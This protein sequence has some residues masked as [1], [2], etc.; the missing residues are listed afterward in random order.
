[1]ITTQECIE[2]KGI[3]RAFLVTLRERWPEFVANAFVEDGSLVIRQP[4]SSGQ[5]ELWITA[6]VDFDE[7]IIGIG[8]G[9]S[10]GGDWRNPESSDYE[11]KSSIAFIEG[12]LVDRV[13]GCTLKNGGGDIGDLAFL[14][15][16]DYWGEVVEVV[17]WL[18]SHDQTLEAK[19][20]VASNGHKRSSHAT[21]T[22][23]TAPAD[24]H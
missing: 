11:F 23:P 14:R 8:G 6:D 13:V 21:S 3:A 19:Q 4:S 1:M 7:I 22:D 24:A 12:I 17:S 5:C 18:G 10:H 16:R 9:H 2:L 15:S 20:G